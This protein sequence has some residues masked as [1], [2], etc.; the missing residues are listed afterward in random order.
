MD[1]VLVQSK[2][3]VSRDGKIIYT[4]LIWETR[5]E[6]RKVF[7]L[8]DDV[9]VLAILGPVHRKLNLKQPMGKTLPAPHL[10]FHFPAILR[11]LCS[12]H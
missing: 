1:D 11:P 12:G 6:G 8:D 9:M 2:W 3:L 7:C 4:Q 10:A 5:I